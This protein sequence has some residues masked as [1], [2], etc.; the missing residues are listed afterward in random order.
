[1]PAAFDFVAL[2]VLAGDD[3]TS[4]EDFVEVLADLDLVVGVFV[5]LCDQRRNL[6]IESARDQPAP[7]CSAPVSASGI[8]GGT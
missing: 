6:T 4:P 8:E 2:S 1:M 5:H 3:P 7:I